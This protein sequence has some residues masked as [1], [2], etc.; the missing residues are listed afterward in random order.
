MTAN[1]SAATTKKENILFYSWLVIGIL[2]VLVAIG[3][4]HSKSKVELAHED[5]F[6]VQTEVWWPPLSTVEVVEEPMEYTGPDIDL[7]LAEFSSRITADQPIYIYFDNDRPLGEVESVSQ[8]IYTVSYWQ[9][10]PSLD[11]WLKTYAPV[12]MDRSKYALTAPTADFSRYKLEKGVLTVY[13]QESLTE[14]RFW[15]LVLLLI[16]VLLAVLV[17]LL[18]TFAFGSVISL[19]N[20]IKKTNNT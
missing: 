1:K 12:T 6:S 8:D 9:Y 18:L 15:A 2:I 7:S 20:D 17:Y 5:H 13:Y 10:A 19:I 3:Y 4:I 16:V 14:A 11:L